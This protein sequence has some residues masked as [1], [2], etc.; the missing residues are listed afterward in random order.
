MFARRITFRSI[1][2]RRRRVA[3]RSG[4]CLSRF[5]HRRSRVRRGDLL[6]VRRFR[7]SAN[8]DGKENGDDEQNDEKNSVDEQSNRQRRFLFERPIGLNQRRSKAQRIVVVNELLI[9][10]AMHIQIVVQLDPVGSILIFDKNLIFVQMPKGVR[11]DP[12]N[13]LTTVDQLQIEC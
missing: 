11:F 3:D 10:K 4:S 6:L 2:S 5:D 1:E 7:R 9:V 12:Q 13:G 8:A